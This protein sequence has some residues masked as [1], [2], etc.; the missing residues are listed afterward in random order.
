MD[1]VGS[2]VSRGPTTLP[3]VSQ[4]R[5]LLRRPES[6]VAVHPSAPPAGA[7]CARA[8]AHRCLLLWGRGG[9]W[10]RGLPP[11]LVTGGGVGPN[12]RSYLRTVSPRRLPPPAR[13]APAQLLGPLPVPECT[14]SRSPAPG[15]ARDLAASGGSSYRERP[16]ALPVNIRTP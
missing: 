15:H 3:R 2:P 8:M 11:L 1:S 12:K 16:R 13:P 10:P 5:V 7:G 9:C 4:I 14:A 6:S